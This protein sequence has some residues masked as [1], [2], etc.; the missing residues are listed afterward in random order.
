MLHA[1][2]HSSLQCV[3]VPHAN[4][5]TTHHY[6]CPFH[7]LRTWQPSTLAGS[8][9][10]SPCSARL[11]S[12]GS[13]ALVLRVHRRLAW[14]HLHLSISNHSIWTVIGFFPCS[15]VFHSRPCPFPDHFP[16]S[17]HLG[18]HRLLIQRSDHPS[19]IS[20][21]VRFSFLGSKTATSS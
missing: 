4:S 16:I 17:F 13:L 9:P 14:L 21:F 10:P 11:I 8:L 2:L 15:A 1:L 20:S 5:G 18:R 6:Y 7:A 19:R 3:F 12:A